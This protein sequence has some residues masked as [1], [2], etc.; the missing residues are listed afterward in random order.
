MKTYK[1][2]TLEET[3]V[4]YLKSKPNDSIGVKNMNKE[5]KIPR[6]HL[7]EILYKSCMFEQS[8]PIHVGSGKWHPLKY[9]NSK[10]QKRLTNIWKLNKPKD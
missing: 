1:Q 7:R 4:D 6:K 3:I 8:L 10:K 9:N 5:L 2:Q